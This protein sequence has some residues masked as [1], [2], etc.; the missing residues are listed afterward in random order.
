MKSRKEVIE[1]A[2]K[3]C[4]RLEKEFLQNFYKNGWPGNERRRA[5]SIKYHLQQAKQGA[6]RT[7]P[8]PDSPTWKCPTCGSRTEPPNSFKVRIAGFDCRYHCA[9][10]AHNTGK[11]VKCC[12]PINGYRNFYCEECKVFQKYGQVKVGYK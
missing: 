10:L 3:L 8:F 1:A 7:I 2:R 9:V 5:E 11:L 12:N 6:G 4:T